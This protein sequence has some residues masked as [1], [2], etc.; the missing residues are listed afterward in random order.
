ML[1]LLYKA[2]WDYILSSK[3]ICYLPSSEK[4]ILY[5]W[6]TRLCLNAFSSFAVSIGTETAPH[7]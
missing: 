6:L 7:C 1:T 3:T 5:P 4:R 2:E